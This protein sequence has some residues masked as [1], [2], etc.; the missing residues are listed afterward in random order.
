MKPM[1]QSKSKF[2]PATAKTLGVT[3]LLAVAL[4]WLSACVSDV[5]GGLVIVQNQIPEIEEGR[6]VIPAKRESLRLFSGVY[7]VY[8]DQDYPYYLHPLVHNGLPPGAQEGQVEPNR[9]EYTGVEVKIEPPPG[10]AFPGTAAC[11]TEFAFNDRASIDPEVDI[12]SRV[13]VL[14]PCHGRLLRDMFEQKLLPDSLDAQVRFRVLVRA[15]GRHAGD[16]VKSEPF[17]FSIQV[18]KGCLQRGFEPPLSTFDYP[19]GVPSCSGLAA[20][21]YRGNPCNP[22]Q[23][24]QIMCCSQDGKLD[25]PGRPRAPAMP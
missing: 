13:Q 15:V 1:Q 10:V 9:I 24:M 8:L 6:C 4:P 17:E 20:N 21:P 16:T 3:A 22:A 14:L 11:P 2:G 23:E 25:C 18:C 12:G 5:N 7:D 19:A